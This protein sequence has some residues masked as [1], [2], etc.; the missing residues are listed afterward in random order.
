MTNVIIVGAGKVGTRLLKLLTKRSGYN[1][2]IID[3]KRC[4]LDLKKKYDDI[5]VIRGDATNKTVLE[6]AGI[7]DADIIV[8]A[9]SVDE[10]NLLIGIVAQNYD[11]QKTIARTNDPSHIKMFKK[12]GLNEV[13]SP[14]LTTVIDIEK[15]IVNPDHIKLPSSEEEDY[16]ITDVIVKSKKA[17]GSTVGSLSPTSKYIVL[18]V[19]R[20]GQY[21]IAQND[22]VLQKEDRVTILTRSQ[23]LNH[24]NNVFYKNSLF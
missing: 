16:I 12:L 6:K 7:E 5:N 18:L 23:D 2:T 9:T 1:I 10:V 3:T 14:E 22:T 11:L 17:I 19:Y 13:V 8:I 4:V 20:D 21:N 15:L 24:A